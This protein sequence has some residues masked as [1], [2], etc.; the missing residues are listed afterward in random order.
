MYRI[1]NAVRALLLLPLLWAV[2]GCQ[3]LGN[4]QSSAHKTPIVDGQVVLIRQGNEA[5]AFILTNQTLNPEQMGFLWFHRSDGGGTFSVDD[6]AVSHGIVSNTNRIVFAT[7]QVNWSGNQQGAGWIYYSRGP[8]EFRKRADFTLGVTGTTN[9]D[10]LNAND[11]A[12]KFR[13]RPGINFRALIQ[14]QLGL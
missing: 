9:L 8:T 6:P 3:P 4:G 5:G 7:F 13:S 2:V 1:P 12:T 14:N 11:G 10:T